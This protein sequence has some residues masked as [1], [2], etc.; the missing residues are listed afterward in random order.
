MP[1]VTRDVTRHATPRRSCCIGECIGILPPSTVDA[2]PVAC[3]SP[4]ALKIRRSRL[5]EIPRPAHKLEAV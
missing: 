1:I 5:V 3:V 2:L 4:V